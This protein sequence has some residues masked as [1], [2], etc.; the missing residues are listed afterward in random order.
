MEIT[1]KEQTISVT[2]D[3]TLIQKSKKTYAVFF[4]FD[5]SWDG[6][7]KTAHFQA[8]SVSSSVAL[9]DDKCDIPAEC[10]KDAG[11]ILQVFVHGVKDSEE[12][13][14]PWCLTSRILYETVIDIPTSQQCHCSGTT[15]PSTPSTPSDEAERLCN[16]FAEI[17]SDYSEDD[18]KDKS[19]ADI[20]GEVCDDIGATA[21]DEE[22]ADVLN[23]VWGPKKEP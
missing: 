1:V 7:V 2:K 13:S 15:T 6:F 5:E 23:D 10:L 18:L 14:T 4:V 21:T 12:K 22:V 19:L 11:I 8:G 17:L 9:T 20:M 16:D 3:D